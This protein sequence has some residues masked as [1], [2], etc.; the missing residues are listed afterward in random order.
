[1]INIQELKQL[2]SDI[3]S[4]RVER[5]VSITKTDKFG[6]TICAFS[7]DL[8]NN[9]KAGYL[10]IGAND[11]G[12]PS[13]IKVTGQLMLNLA[14]LRSDGNIQPLPQM[15]VQ[16]VIID[17]AEFAVIEVF[18]SIIPPVRYKDTVWVRIGSRKARASEQE[19]RV[20]IEKNVSSARN[21]DA[22]ATKG[23]SVNDLS[24]SLFASY[25][26]QVVSSDVIEENHRSTEHKLASLRFY[27][28]KQK[29][30]TNAGL[31]LFG[32]N[33]RYF[34]SG[35]Y[36]Q[37]LKIAGTLLTD[38]IEDQAEI[39]GD[40]LSVLRELDTRIKTNIH[41][42]LK[43]ETILREKMVYDYPE[44]AVRELLMNA[45][46]HRDYQSNMPVKLYWFADRIEIHNAGGTY[47]VVT[48]DTLET[49]SDY[50]NPVIAEA[51]KALGYVNR[52][53][54]GIQ[55]AQAELKENGN[56]PAEFKGDSKTFLAIIHK[57]I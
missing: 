47:G 15:N 31:L 21:F 11:D 54:Y 17:N 56:P 19:E 48:L 12:T 20:L 7:N 6:E 26:Q 39:D 44:R 18:P 24:L 28:I 10:I 36:V 38:D 46:L 33:P 42:T 14:S 35:A 34:L 50:R 27:D 52:F 1:M 51:M 30:A 32:K 16:K 45:I 40:L 29:C 53:G 49:T 37:Y 3:E 5:T 55:K 57:R 8:A 9:C 43:Q 2:L 4:D 22:C 13:G 41:S 25:W 23:S